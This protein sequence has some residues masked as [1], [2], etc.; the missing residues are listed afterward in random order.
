MALLED[1]LREDV[2]FE[3]RFAV[4]YRAEKKKIIRSNI[5][6]VQYILRILRRLNDTLDEKQNSN[7]SKEEF[8]D[9]YLEKTEL[10]EEGTFK[11][12]I[13]GS[14]YDEE[15]NYYRRRLQLREYF[16]DLAELTGIITQ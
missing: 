3:E 5:D 10:E 14:E 11:N 1:Y 16:K 4:R 6:L 9:L 12:W 8:R 15:D 2:T 7:L 13:I